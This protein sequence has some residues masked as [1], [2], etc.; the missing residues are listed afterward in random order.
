MKARGLA[1]DDPRMLFSWYSGE[2]CTDPAFAN[3]PSEQ[4]ANPS[5]DS[6]PEGVAYLDQQR[7]RLPTHKFRRLHLNL[8][9]A[10]NGAF[11]DGDLV[12][13]ATVRGMRRIPYQEDRIYCGFVDMS[14][15]SQDDATFA[16]AHQEGRRRVL[17][18]LISQDGGVPF[19][20]RNAVR[21]FKRTCEEYGLSDV[22]GDA[23]AGLTFRHD[24]ESEG[25]S[26]R[27]SDRNKTEIYEAF[28]PLLNAGEIELLDVPK[29]QEQLLTLVVRGSSIDHPSGSHD[30]FANAAC[31]A[32]TLNMDELTALT[33]LD[34]EQHWRE[35]GGGDDRLG[36][37]PLENW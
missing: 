31:G 10:P 37:D 18:L 26:Y 24:F 32:L 27:V 15:G 4:R 13:Q 35:H 3:L 14:G 25:I 21:K 30:D 8:P 9:G 5:M 19:N 12:S 6:W 36:S 1:G 2:L 33:R 20:P 17:D 16:I 7:R 22:T 29:L 23:Y 11:L 34:R 28:E